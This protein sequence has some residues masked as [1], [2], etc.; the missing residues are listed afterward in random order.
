MWTHLCWPQCVVCTYPD[1]LRLYFLNNE[2]FSGI[3]DLH[4]DSVC[5]LFCFCILASSLDTIFIICLDKFLSVELF[6]EKN[7]LQCVHV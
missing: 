3:E 7:T 6:K 5:N 2:R 1:S 4:D